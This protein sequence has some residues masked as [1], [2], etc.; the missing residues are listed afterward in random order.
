[1]CWSYEALHCRL[2]KIG[3]D[4]RVMLG[5]HCCPALQEVYEK[6]A[7]LVK[8]HFLHL[9]GWPWIFLVVMT[10]D[11]S[12][13]DFVVLILVGSD[14]TKTH[15]QPPLMPGTHSHPWHS[16][17]V[18]HSTCF[19][20]WLRTVGHPLGTHFVP[21]QSFHHD[22][23]NTS[24][25]QSDLSSYSFHCNLAVLGN[26]SINQLDDVI[27]YAVWCSRLRIIG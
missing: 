3:Q 20:L 25:A 4:F 8:E 16:A 23:V 1:M 22:G 2:A 5:I 14:D 26:E 12:T 11:A 7:I 18:G 24:D 21:V 27:G 15:L 10:L 13:G 6:G 19:L 9:C 17:A